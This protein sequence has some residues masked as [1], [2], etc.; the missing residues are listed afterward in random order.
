MEVV[1]G[2]TKML[3]LF[4]NCL[5]FLSAWQIYASVRTAYAPERGP[6][7]AHW[8]E[9]IVYYGQSGYPWSSVLNYAIS[10]FQM[11]QNEAPECWFSVDT[12]LTQNFLVNSLAGKQPTTMP[13]TTNRKRTSTDFLPV[14]QQ[15]CRNWNHSNCSG[16]M[17]NGQPCPRQ[18]VC[19]VC[20]GNH[21][22]P[23]CTS[24]TTQ[25]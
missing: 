18:H 7:L 22:S 8:A 13:S 2:H 3:S 19:G 11:Y 16:V 21:K 14:N 24:K 25:N 20:K 4:P 17:L 6:G 5:A 23:Q 1:T 12:E 10:Y 9:R 15:I